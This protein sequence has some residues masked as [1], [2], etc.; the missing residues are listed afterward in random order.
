MVRIIAFGEKDNLYLSSTA[1]RF[2]KYSV[3]PVNPVGYIFF[4][5]LVK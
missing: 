4:G 5:L 1:K 2:H 3:N